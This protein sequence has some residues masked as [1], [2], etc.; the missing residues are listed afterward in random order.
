MVLWTIMP[1]ELIFQEQNTMEKSPVYEEVDLEGKKVIVERCS[2]NQSK[3]V[4]I[5]S[6]CPEDY[7]LEELQPGTMLTYK[8]TYEKSIT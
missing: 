6:T 1:S 7:M 8:P 2:P 5:I 3:I 4:R